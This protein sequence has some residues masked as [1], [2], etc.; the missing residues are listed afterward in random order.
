MLDAGCWMLDSPPNKLFAVNRHAPFEP[1][2]FRS[3]PAITANRH[4]VEQFV[5]ENNAI[6]LRIADCG[7]RIGRGQGPEVV[8]PPDVRNKILQCFPL[9]PPSLRRRL[10]NPVFDL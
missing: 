3:V 4:G 6:Q 8:E 9:P 5:A 7:L 2:L 1:T 10:K